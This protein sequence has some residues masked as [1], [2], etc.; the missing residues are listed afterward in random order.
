MLFFQCTRWIALLAERETAVADQVKQLTEIVHV[1]NMTKIHFQIP[2]VFD[3][4]RLV[5]DAVNRLG[6][7]LIL[8]HAVLQH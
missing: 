6:N 4:T 1:F 5:A 2:T 3:A 8:R 7:D